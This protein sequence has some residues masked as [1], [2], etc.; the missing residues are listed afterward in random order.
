MK[1]ALIKVPVNNSYN[2]LKKQLPFL[3]KVAGK[4]NHT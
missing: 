4:K 1:V 3:E 2:S